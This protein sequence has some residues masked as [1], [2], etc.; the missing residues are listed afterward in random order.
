MTSKNL[1]RKTSLLLPY[2]F[3]PTTGNSKQ[4]ISAPSAPVAKLQ[5]IDA[6]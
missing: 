2:A 1:N 6:A 3:A 5:F 4:K